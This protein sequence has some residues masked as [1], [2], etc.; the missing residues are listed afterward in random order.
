MSTPFYQQIFGNLIING[1]SPDGDSIRFKANNPDD[2][3][4][5][6]RSDRIRIAKD[7]TV[8]LRLE[9]ID[10]PELHYGSFGQPLGRESRDKL[11]QLA[12]F[13][14]VKYANEQKIQVSASE[15][16]SIPATILSQRSDVNGRPVAYLFLTTASYST[17]Q[18][19][20]Q[21]LLWANLSVTSLKNSL[22]YQMVELGLAYPIFYS[23]MP[24]NYLNLFK[25]TA[26]QSRQ[27]TKGVWQLD[28][29]QEFRLV[30]YESITESGDLIFPKLF[31]RSI[32]YL[33]SVEEGYKG[34]L[35]DWIQ[36]ISSQ[37]SRNENDKVLVNNQMEFYLSDL[38]VQ[39][40][41]RVV[42]KTDI[43]DM[44]F[45]EK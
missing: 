32:D 41:D 18:D 36:W 35:S 40:N 17:I 7:G 3:K 20:D 38:I 9:G 26:I 15:P 33:K 6:Y 44:V 34:N 31:R 45:V 4:K 24:T 1:K 10:A 5:L 12:G 21:D 19:S 39:R 11:L 2:L 42:L 25:E 22:N 13:E 23:S 29:S 28:Q 43:L 27:E 16:E 8:Q 14:H 37:N 30:N